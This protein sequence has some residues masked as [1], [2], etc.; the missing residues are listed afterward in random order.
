MS[1]RDELQEA[2][3]SFSV[4]DYL[5]SEGIEYRLT[6]GT[7]GAQL[8][9]KCC[10]VCG[11]SKWKVYVGEETGLGNCFHGDCEAKFNKFSFIKAQS[12]LLGKE[13]VEYIK[14]LSQDFGW[15]P[16]KKKVEAVKREVKLEIP[17]SYE[18]PYHGN[19]LAY[20]ENRGISA[21][22]A[23]Y[24]GLRFCDKGAFFYFLP[25][26]KVGT[27]VYDRRV[28]IPIHDMQGNLVSFQGR[29]ISGEAEKKYLFP[30]GFSATGAYLYNAHNV[31]R[32]AKRV[33]IGEGAFDVIAQKIALLSDPGFADIEPIGTFGKHLSSG[34]DNSQIQKFIALRELGVEE[35]TFMWDGEQQALIDALKAGNSLRSIGLNVRIA[36]LPKGK[37]PN[38]VSKEVVIKSYIDAI[39][40]TKAGA[41]K[42]LMKNP[43]K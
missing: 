34:E 27:Q 3:D 42:L 26:G 39:P 10:P 32:G 23:E 33:L 11:G 5:D 16:K 19:N 21:E 25:D 30:P 22:M 12:G 35:A 24:F 37:D 29:D 20:L 38:E 31:K 43:Y 14:N 36:L 2:M 18:I 4:Q 1:D 8:N 17:T 28:I 13:L 9:L 41:M 7:R 15:M 6:T 40:L